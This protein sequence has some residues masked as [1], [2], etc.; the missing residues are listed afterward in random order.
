LSL[1]EVRRFDVPRDIAAGT[2]RSLRKAGRDGYELFVFWSG[3][4]EDDRFLVRNG[5]VPR[6]TS[7]RTRS[8]LMVRVEGDAL[9]RLNVWLYEHGET[10]G[11]QVHAHPDD[12]YHSDTDDTFP[13]V[14]TLGGLS[15]VV[16]EFCRAGLLP[17][18]AAFR[19]T[20]D[21]WTQSPCPVRQL[22]EVI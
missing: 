5:H 18:S 17:G 15:L 9:H 12:A 21:G 7:S 2:E 19:L 22:V 4:I 10:L 3:L 11:A 1:V 16:P 8:G 6:Q 20:E 13:I 14:T